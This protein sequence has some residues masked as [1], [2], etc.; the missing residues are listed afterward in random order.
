[1]VEAEV[2]GTVVGKAER[3]GWFVRKIAY[4]GRR[5][6]ADRLFIKGGRTVWIEFKRPGKTARPG[7][8]LE[9]NRM[10]GAGAEVHV[11]DRVEDGLAILG[12]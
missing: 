7:Q 11:V 9:I 6:A 8:A 5:A 4:V 12:L 1:M 10:K 3:A 2:E